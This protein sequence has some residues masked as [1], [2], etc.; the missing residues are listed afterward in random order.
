MSNSTWLEQEREAQQERDEDYRERVNRHMPSDETRKRN[1]Q[2]LYIGIDPGKSG[3][4][5]YVYDDD[6]TAAVA[7]KMPATD[8]DIWL[9]LCCHDEANTRV[10]IEKVGPS[11]GHDNGRQQGVS[12][13]FRFGLNYGVLR[14]CLVA[15]GI[16]FDVVSPQK[17]QREFGLVF[18]KAM[19]L[20]ST[21]KKNRHK[22]KAQELFPHLKITHAIADALLIAEWARRQK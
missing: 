9:A 13:A 20:T 6:A 15:S 21:E 7:V 4:I 10:A 22:A 18:P 8:R 11:R 1:N 19:G 12:S 16:P 14:G 17:W 2:M 3:G 5:A